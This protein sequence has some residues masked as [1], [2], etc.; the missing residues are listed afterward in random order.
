[1]KIAG[2]VIL[3]NP[4]KEIFSNI[5][6]YIDS[7]DYLYVF[8]NSSIGNDYLPEKYHHKSR[9]IHS[10]ENNGIAK[11]L[12]Q[13]INIA[14]NDNFNYLLTMDQ[15]SSF[16]ENDLNDYLGLVNNEI[17]HEFISMFGIR[18]YAKKDNTENQATYNQLLITSGSI[19]NLK[20][21][22]SIE[23]FD[24]N[25]FIDGVDTEF[26]LKSFKNGFK[27]VFY[28]QIYLRHNL[29]DEK[30][31]T[32]PFLKKRTRKIHNPLR[33]YYIVRNYL[34]LRKQYRNLHSKINL[35]DLINELKNCLFYGGQKIEYLRAILMA[36][37]DVNRSQMGKLNNKYAFKLN[38]RI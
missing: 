12:N 22:S 21:A 7:I 24:E 38:N 23:G 35:P 14:K 13:A 8:D 5:R 25:L 28:Q 16:D 11:C 17:N 26:C 2:V 20:I 4:P 37:K 36:I 27:T 15:D 29:G 18:Y 10:G 6:S 33:L 30:N 3:Y 9:Y 34:Y 32:I 31:I 19:I 1:M